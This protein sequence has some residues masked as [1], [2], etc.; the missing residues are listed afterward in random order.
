MLNKILTI[1]LILTSSV[2]WAG[3]HPSLL[4][5]AREAAQIKN[6]LGKYPVLDKTFM[7]TKARIDR[8]IKLPIEVPPPG[9]AGGYAHEKHKQNYRDM[10]EAGIMFVITNND[11]Y[12][13]FVRNMLYKY[14]E[15]YPTLGPH[16][17][18]HNQAPGK[19]FHQMLNETVWLV[20]TS[21]A[22]DCIYSW[23]KPEDR[24]YIEKNLFNL[25]IDWFIG[26]NAHEFDRVHNHGTWSVASV[27]MIG[28]VLG[29]DDLVEKALYGTDLSGKGGFLKQLDM[30]FSPD[31]YYMEGPYYAR[32]ALR[33]FFIFAEALQRNRPEVKI[34]EYRNHILK[35]ALY[36]AFMTTFPNGVFPPINDASQTM[37]ISSPGPVYANNIGYYRYGEGDVNLL[38]IAKV[39]DQVLLNGCGLKLARDM[40]GHAGSIPDFTWKSIEFTDGA[41]GQQGGLGILRTGTG[42]DQMMLLMKYGVHGEGHGHFD[43][44]QFLLYDQGREIIPDYGFARWINVETKFGGRYLPE[45]KTYAMQTIAHNTVT[46][47]QKTQ[48]NFDQKEADLMSGKRH[49]FYSD[50]PDIQVMSAR[51]EDYYPDVNMQRT[52]FLIRDQRLDWP[53]IVDL[54]RLKSSSPHIYDYPIHFR[55]QLMT[56]SFSYVA[57]TTRIGVLGENNGYQHLWREARS[58]IID[59]GSASVTWLDGNRYYTALMAIDNGSEIIF[60]R[61][62]A[63]DPSFNLRSEPMFLLRL[64]AANYLFATVIEPHGYFNEAQE[65]SDGARP[66]LSEIN[67]IGSNDI[68]SVIEIKGRDDISWR[69]IVT[70]ESSNPEA[71]RSVIFN[72]RSFSWSGDYLVLLKK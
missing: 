67:I 70:N 29:R 41:D 69:I 15:M 2:L 65:K 17:L 35:K 71:E 47:D 49:F 7:E 13:V 28:I 36:S 12:A 24:A 32:Y 62:G 48:N 61:T 66:V 40:A 10:Q 26:R 6:A 43:E 1:V 4:I 20:Y 51:A 68:A 46:V 30:L 9:E 14:A 22:Y 23:L 25:I 33:P 59:N 64:Q 45:N 72:D 31:G 50:N 21:M 39:Q 27:G 34:F 52:L 5:N 55:G 37:D 42:R 44:L 16:P 53:V 58:G 57:D 19:L 38:G 60:A 54:Y 11:D 3:E 18:S 56:T 8:V 63:G